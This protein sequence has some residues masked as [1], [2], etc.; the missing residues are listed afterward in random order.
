MSFLPEEKRQSKAGLL[1][2]KSNILLEGIGKKGYTEYAKRRLCEGSF[3]KR[4][5]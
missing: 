2:K 4:S 5:V 3:L 1:R